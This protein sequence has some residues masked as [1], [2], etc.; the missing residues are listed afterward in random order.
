MRARATCSDVTALRGKS[1]GMEAMRGGGRRA[2][3][4]IA[5]AREVG[6][7]AGY[8]GKGDRCSYAAPSAG[9]PAEEARRRGRQRDWDT[10]RPAMV[11]TAPAAM[12]IV[13]GSP[14][15]ATAIAMVMTG[16][17]Y[18]YVMVVTGPRRLSAA[19][20]MA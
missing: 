13:N 8:C 11:R 17:R 10:A 3:G 2:A 5:A 12:A 16:T 1:G 18:W 7:V 15:T 6:A 4:G 9:A 20:H 19:F 14:S